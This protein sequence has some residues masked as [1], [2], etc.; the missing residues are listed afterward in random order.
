[1]FPGSGLVLEPVGGGDFFTQFVV[2]L[3]NQ[4]RGYVYLL[5]QPA[6]LADADQIVHV[7]PVAP[8]QQSG[9]V[10]AAVTPEHDAGIRPVLPDELHQQGQNGPAVAAVTAAAGAQVAHQQV[11][12][13]EHVQRKV[14][15][16]VVISVKELAG[17]VAMHRN[18]GAIEVQHDF[19]GWGV[20]L[21]NEVMPQQFV[22]LDHGLPVYA[23]LHSAQC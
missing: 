10:K 6:V 5:E 11:T 3:A 9:T 13:A 21:L 20:V 22:G 2:S 8:A 14:A 1:M 17:L 18:V 4:H 7:V 12:A 19:L 23:L 15:V 16:V